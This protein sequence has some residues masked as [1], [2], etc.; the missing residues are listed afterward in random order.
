MC[1]ELHVA[2]GIASFHAL[3]FDCFVHKKLMGVG[4]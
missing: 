2:V 4:G 3:V 1:M